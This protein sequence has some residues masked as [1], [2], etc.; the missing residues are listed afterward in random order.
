MLL[1]SL[2]FSFNI[3]TAI[4]T[5]AKQMKYIH[6]LRDGEQWLFHGEGITA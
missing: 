3:S 2:G 4:I 5:T 6:H 1:T